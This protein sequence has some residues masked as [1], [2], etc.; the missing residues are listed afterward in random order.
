MAY[1][2]LPSKLVMIGDGAVGKT[3]LLISY[4]TDSFPTEYVPTVFGALYVALGA[5][6]STGCPRRCAITHILFTHR[7]LRSQYYSR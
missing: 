4:T 7:Q 3:C 6:L 1:T 2:G 5:C